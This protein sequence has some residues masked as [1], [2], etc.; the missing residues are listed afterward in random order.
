MVLVFIFSFHSDDVIWILKK[1]KRTILL[2]NISLY[3]GACKAYVGGKPAP[4]NQNGFISLVGLK[5]HNYSISKIVIN[6][7]SSWKCNLKS[8]ILCSLCYKIYYKI[9]ISKPPMRLHERSNLFNHYVQPHKRLPQRTKASLKY[10][11]GQEGLRWREHVMASEKMVAFEVQ[12][13]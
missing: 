7:G 9:S 3:V 12:G 13:T 4:R 5:E 11:K 10:S 6:V 2:L 1:K 8:N